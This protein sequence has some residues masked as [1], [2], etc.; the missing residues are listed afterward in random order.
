MDKVGFLGVVKRAFDMD[1]RPEWLAKM[2]DRP[3]SFRYYRVFVTLARYM[4]PE[5]IVELGTNKGTGALHFKHGC[6]EAKV[7]TVDIYV[8]ANDNLLA[9]H[10]IY[11]PISDSADYAS[12]VDDG[13]VDI[14]FIDTNS[15]AAENPQ[16]S[17]GR[18]TEEIEAW[19]P[20]MKPGGIILFD[21]IRFNEG[22]LQAWDELEGNK[23][24]V[25]ELH[26]PNVS[27]GVLLL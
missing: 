21:D 15:C 14:L 9:E 26:P 5:L 4:Q 27:F 8:S 16:V 3:S 10:G 1:T 2:V 22:M 25:R 24:E 11:H 13:R 23:L 7:I 17:Y 19:L 6:P 12:L 18:I 20:K